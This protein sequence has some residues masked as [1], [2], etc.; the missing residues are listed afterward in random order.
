[1]LQRRVKVVGAVMD[2]EGGGRKGRR[3]VCV[4]VEEG[5]QIKN[6]VGIKR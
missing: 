4:C 1:M 5:V 6:D 3:E 2:E